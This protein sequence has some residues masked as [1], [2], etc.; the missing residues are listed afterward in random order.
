VFLFL[1]NYHILAKRNMK[2]ERFAKLRPEKFEK[3]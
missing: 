2:K 3:E 1:A